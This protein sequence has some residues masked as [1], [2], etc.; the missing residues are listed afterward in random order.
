MLAMT[1]SGR[2]EL[3]ELLCTRLPSTTTTEEQW[4][5]ANFTFHS[6]ISRTLVLVFLSL[7]IPLDSHRLPSLSP[8]H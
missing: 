4:W 5:L 1:L 6:G 3:V 8:T 2:L 7:L